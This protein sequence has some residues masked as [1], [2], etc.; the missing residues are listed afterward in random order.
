VDAQ[1]QKVSGILLENPGFQL[2]MRKSL[3]KKIAVPYCGL[4]TVMHSECTV[5]GGCGQRCPTVARA[6]AGAVPALIAENSFCYERQ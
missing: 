2:A 4:L 3:S 1:S 6:R 5:E